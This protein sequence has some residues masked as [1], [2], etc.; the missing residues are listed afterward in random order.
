RH[1][2]RKTTLLSLLACAVLLPALLPPRRQ[3]LPVVAVLPAAVPP[4]RS[5]LL[6]QPQLSPPAA[7]LA[8]LLLLLPLPPPPPTLLPSPP[9]PAALREALL[10]LRPKIQPRLPLL[11]PRTTAFSRPPPIPMPAAP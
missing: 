10:P 9:Y 4:D 3:H 6:P 5:R 11:R 8:T 7:A 1:C 2:C